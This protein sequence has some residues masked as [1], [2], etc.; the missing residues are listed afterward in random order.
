MGKK[1]FSIEPHFLTE[2]VHNSGGKKK[3]NKELPGVRGGGDLHAIK[4]AQ[5]LIIILLSLR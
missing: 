4:G 5:T 2:G 3:A 1:I